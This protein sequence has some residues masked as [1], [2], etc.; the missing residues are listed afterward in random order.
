M[1]EMWMVRGENRYRIVM[2]DREVITLSNRFG[3][4]FEVGISALVENGYRLEC[5][6]VAPCKGLAPGNGADVPH[7]WQEA[8]GWVARKPQATSS[9][10]DTLFNF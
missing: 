5:E 2:I 3:A 9:V 8:G 7:W 1:S 4:E 10:W 6:G